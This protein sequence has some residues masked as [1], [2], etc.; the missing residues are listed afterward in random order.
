[1]AQPGDTVVDY[2]FRRPSPR[3]IREAGYVGAMRYLAGGAGQGKEITDLER[4]QLHEEG[5]GLGL[6]WETT[7]ARARD[8]F[9][10][11]QRDAI[12]ANAQLDA[13]GAPD[14]AVFYAVDFDVADLSSIEPYFDGVA[15]AGGREAGVYGEYAVV[16][17]L[18]GSGR[19][20]LGW[21]CAAWSGNGEGTG[22]S[23]Q[24]RRLSKH[25][26]LFQHVG[27]VLDD[28]S[29]HNSVTSSAGGWLWTPEGVNDTAPDYTKETDA[30]PLAQLERF[31]NPDGRAEEIAL[32]P[33][34]RLYNR[35]QDSPDGDLNDWTPLVPGADLTFLAFTMEDPIPPTETNP[36][37]GAVVF[38][39]TAP[40]A[41]VFVTM[42]SGPNVGPWTGFAEEKEL[43]R[44]FRSLAEK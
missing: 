15:R 37:R 16:E 14:V 27:Y 40:Y 29:D 17:H 41:V 18:V 1:M 7:A 11:G 33:D 28:T 43:G 20:R 5:L 26:T 24:R 36:G 25:A 21:Q 22:G 12:R 32:F 9:S 35:W 30:V 42:Q 8:G 3:R 44:F 19:M 38:G 31:H 23:I 10:A 4:R 6:V 34:G 39:I 13:L 2:S